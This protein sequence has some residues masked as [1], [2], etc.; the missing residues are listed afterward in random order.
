[1]SAILTARL[2]VSAAAL[3][4]L[5]LALAKISARS[6]H[7]GGA[8]ALLCDRVDHNDIQLVVAG[9]LIPSSSIFMHKPFHLSIPLPES[10]C[11]MAMGATPASEIAQRGS[12]CINGN[13]MLRMDAAEL[14]MAQSRTVA[15]T[16]W[17]EDR[18][19]LP[20]TWP[21]I[22]PHA[23]QVCSHLFATL[24]V[25]WLKDAAVEVCQVLRNKNGGRSLPSLNERRVVVVW[26]QHFNILRKGRNVACVNGLLDILN[27]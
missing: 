6:A 20:V 15:E 19:R 12:N 2:R 13:W 14:E 17:L 23:I 3:P 22:L 26:H 24:L 4:H 16:R 8:M 18:A 5:G 21:N 9:A 10:C 1:M 11:V 27:N 7:A 25:A